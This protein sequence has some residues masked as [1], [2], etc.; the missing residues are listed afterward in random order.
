M[1]LVRYTPKPVYTKDVLKVQVLLPLQR[2]L[3]S[4]LLTYW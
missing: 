1:I 2:H 3:M 4:L